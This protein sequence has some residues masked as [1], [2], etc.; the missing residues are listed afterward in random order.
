MFSESRAAIRGA[1]R[2]TMQTS[3]IFWK[4][5]TNTG[6]ITAYILYRRLTP[7]EIPAAA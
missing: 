4:M 3:D 6:S 1:V 5:F 7:G 2:T